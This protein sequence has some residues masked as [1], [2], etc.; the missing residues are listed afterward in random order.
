MTKLT[1]SSYSFTDL[2]VFLFQIRIF[3][4]H[5]VLVFRICDDIKSNTSKNVFLLFFSWLITFLP[6]IIIIF[7][8]WSSTSHS[9]GWVDDFLFINIRWFLWT[10]E[11]IFHS[12]WLFVYLVVLRILTI[13]LI[14]FISWH[15]ITDLT[16][17][18]ILSTHSLIIFDAFPLF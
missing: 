11:I 12:V 10:C 17:I 18:A 9:T 3:S 15:F 5:V 4:L 8:T 6:W 7:I 16:R 1:S 13:V 2:S 14:D